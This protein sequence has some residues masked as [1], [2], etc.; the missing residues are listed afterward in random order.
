MGVMKIK[1]KIWIEV[2]GRPVFGKG[3]R[4]LLEAVDKWG[5]INQAA[6]E[7]NMSYRKAWGHLNAMEERLGIKL[8]ERKSGGRNGGGATLTEDA[9]KLL[10]K[11]RRME[12]GLQRT[13]DQRFKK[14]FERDIM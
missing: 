11:F 4:Y 6:R 7:T 1:F 14:I 13:V 5:S 8:I 12:K 9:K 2:D 3:K 10:K